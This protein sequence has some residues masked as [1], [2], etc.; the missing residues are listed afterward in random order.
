MPGGGSVRGLN[1]EDI[2]IRFVEG[3]T[4][5]GMPRGAKISLALNEPK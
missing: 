3:Q 1:E 5:F 2:L 4:H